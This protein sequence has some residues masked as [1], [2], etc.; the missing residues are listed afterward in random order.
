MPRER[1][2]AMRARSL[3]ALARA[4]LLVAACALPAAHA[5][6]PRAVA[7]A[8]L[9]QG[10]P[11]DA[12]ALWVERAGEP[13][14]L[15]T[16]QPDRPMNPA[17]VMKLVTTWTA[18]NVLGPDYRWTTEAYLGGPLVDGV[19]KGDLMLKGHGDPKITIEQWQAFMEALRANGLVRVE[20]D[21]VLDR[22]WFRLPSYD[23]GR[24]DAEPLRPYNVGPD[25][26]LVNFKSVRFVF[27]PSATGDA[28]DVRAEPALPAVAIASRPTLVAGDCGDWR[29]ALSAQ[30]DGGSSSATAAF[31]GRYATGCG[32]RDFNVALLDHP[33]Y[34]HAMFAAY[35]AAAGG[36]FAGGVREGTVPAGARPF[37]TL[38]SPPLA[39]VVRDVNKFSN[40]V[41]ARQVFLTLA[42]AGGREPATPAA[43]TDTVVR[44][45][46][47][48]K[49]R[50][51][52]LVLDNGSG[53][54][55]QER[56]TVRGLARILESAEASPLRETF[57]AS[58]PV[59][60]IDGT[61]EKRFRNGAVAGQAF[62]KTGTL[63]GVRALAGYVF[64]AE[65]RRF[66]VVAIVNHPKAAAA[67]PALDR[68][69]E[70]V[71]RFGGA[72]SSGSAIHCW[73]SST[74]S[75]SSASPKPRSRARS[76]TCRAPA[77]RSTS[78]TTFSCPRTCAPPT[79][80]C[81]TPGTCRPRS[82]RAARPRACAHCS[83]RRRATEPT[84]RSAA[85]R[86]PGSRSSSSRSRHAD[87][88]C[89]RPATTPPSSRASRGTSSRL[90]TSAGI[91][92]CRSRPGAFSRPAGCP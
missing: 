17:S 46:A 19:L 15:A 11:L 26:L 8:F 7:R 83:R 71:Y 80:S 41:M 76:T 37:A 55:R 81:A 29:A 12:V 53:L 85:A 38:V 5:A 75:P 31:P 6:L 57:A 68:L 33:H 24:F 47:R 91:E 60:A 32:E 84:N 22:S 78:A 20:G 63:E 30:F 9:D 77:G 74:A 36:T 66:V 82:R 54:S 25:A 86:R 79:A 52:G 13:R 88:R 62:L 43:A 61:L 90:R 65:G 23:P 69:V 42:T 18:L 51:P 21:L 1:S 72:A 87:A 59:A 16:L 56:V 34:V 4:A 2:G 89:A 58:L 50:V 45:L 3:R 10:I 67:N 35:F 40:N 92:A 48:E 64:D 73:T 28:V 39:D 70:W 27:A 49:I 44:W 14:P